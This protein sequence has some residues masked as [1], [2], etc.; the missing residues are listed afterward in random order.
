M[1]IKRMY[2]IFDKKRGCYGDIRVCDND[3][4]AYKDYYLNNLR[5]IRENPTEKFEDNIL[6]YLGDCDISNYVRPLEMR[7]GIEITKEMIAKAQQD[8]LKAIK[9]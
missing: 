6:V 7:C 9:E 4:D 1:N 8:I 3:L 2:T 5:Y